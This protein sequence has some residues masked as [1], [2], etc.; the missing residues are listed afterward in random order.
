M[1]A[2]ATRMVQFVQAMLP[3][4]VASHGAVIHNAI[5]KLHRIFPTEFTDV[6]SLSVC[7]EV[8]R[9]Q[10]GLVPAV[11]DSCPNCNRDLYA[12]VDETECTNLVRGLTAKVKCCNCT[13]HY[14]HA[15]IP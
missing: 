11:Y 10:S 5:D 12:A 15:A 6:C 8:Q 7:G 1:I 9:R 2:S 3:E 14:T 13:C 4:G